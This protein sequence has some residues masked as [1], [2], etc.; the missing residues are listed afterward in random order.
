MITVRRIRGRRVVYLD[1]API[2]L[3]E[4][5]IKDQHR[6]RAF[7]LEFVYVPSEGSPIPA[8][9][10]YRAKTVREIVYLMSRHAH[11]Q[12]TPS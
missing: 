11:A 4:T 10:H 7:G 2:G 3:I 5:R 8:H 9:Y 6:N 12:G 1:G